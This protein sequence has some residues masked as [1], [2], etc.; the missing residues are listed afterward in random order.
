[1][2]DSPWRQPY[3]AR[4]TFGEVHNLVDEYVFGQRLR[5]LDVGCGRG[6]LSL[7]LAR[8]GH[9]VM[10]IDSEKDMI[11]SSKKTMESDPYKNERGKLEFHAA[12]FSQWDYPLD[13]FDLVIFSRSLHHIPQPSKAVSKAHDL[14]KKNGQIIC[15]EYA[16]DRVDKR[17]AT[18]I[19]Q[20]RRSLQQ[21]GWY[22]SRKKLSDNT[23][24]SVKD[25]MEEYDAPA[26]KEHFNRFEEMRK[27]LNTLFREVHFSWEPYIYWDLIMDMRIPSKD[28]EMATAQSIMSMESA[29]IEAETINPVLFCF[30]GLKQPNKS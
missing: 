25:I 12:D 6:W 27:P 8:E 14:L 7:E 2:K 16:Y 10:G 4:L 9:D 29:L 30:V 17:T 3:L 19:Y 21:S 11:R 22:K 26:R 5:I 20:V 18:W 15:I 28:V 1:M 24:Q 13:T 23:D